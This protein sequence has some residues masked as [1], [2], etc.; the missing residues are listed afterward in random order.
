VGGADA[1]QPSA[2]ARA[3]S[4]GSGVTRRPGCIAQ[5]RL[6]GEQTEGMLCLLWNMYMCVPRL[7]QLCN[8]NAVM[9]VDTGS[10]RT[11]CPAEPV[12]S[13]FPF[14]LQHRC[15][16]QPKDCLM[17]WPAGATSEMQDASTTSP[18]NVP[19]LPSRLGQ[20]TG[21]ASLPSPASTAGLGVY[22]RPTLGQGQGGGARVARVSRRLALLM[23]I[24]VT[25]RSQVRPE[26]FCSG[27]QRQ[28][29][30]S[31]VTRC[32]ASISAFQCTY[33]DDDASMMCCRS[34]HILH[35]FCWL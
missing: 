28:R 33:Q 25:Y 27:H 14:M 6:P 3:D 1:G 9:S 34:G 30:L 35:T 32:T 31:T 18:G 20:Q 29:C 26:C 4:T 16:S 7:Q 8:Y 23:D 17:N 11:S 10:V 12:Y 15:C 13:V 24:T 21:P 2:M 5:L 19:Y 22:G